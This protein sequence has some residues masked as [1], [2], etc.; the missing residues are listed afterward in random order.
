MATDS[1]LDGS[2]RDINGDIAIWLN[3]DGVLK[4][5]YGKMADAITSEGLSPL[6]LSNAIN[7][8]YM[9][10]DSIRI[11]FLFSAKKVGVMTNKTMVTIMLRCSIYENILRNVGA[12]LRVAST[13]R[14]YSTP[15]SM[16][17]DSMAM[18]AMYGRPEV[19]SRRASKA[20]QLKF[21]Q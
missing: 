10:Q 16:Y 11:R 6:D 4:S 15:K 1:D 14:P 9:V 3:D 18:V 8:L 20:V 17:I 19:H 21:D 12:Y 7:A 13:K 2:I 5:I